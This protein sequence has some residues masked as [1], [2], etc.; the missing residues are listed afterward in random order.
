MFPEPRCCRLKESTLGN[1]LRPCLL[2]H[3]KSHQRSSDQRLRATMIRVDMS[4][5]SGSSPGFQGGDTVLTQSGSAFPR[6]HID[7]HGAVRNDSRLIDER[8]GEC[9]GRWNSGEGQADCRRDSERRETCLLRQ[10]VDTSSVTSSRCV[11]RRSRTMI[12]RSSCSNGSRV[13]SVRSVRIVLVVAAVVGGD[14]ATFEELPHGALHPL[15]DG[16]RPV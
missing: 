9:T 5:K 14:E 1:R 3:T 7:S 13:A 15:L 4:R 16:V 10:R 6:T 12:G 8:A 11:R 2:T